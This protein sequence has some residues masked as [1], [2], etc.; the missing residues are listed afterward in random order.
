M[1]TNPKVHSIVRASAPPP[2]PSLEGL[3]RKRL[4]VCVGCGGVGKTTT[5]AALALAGAQHGRRAAVITVDP[6]RRLKDALG[7]EGLSVD[8]HRVTIDATAHFDA[9][10]L[11]TKRAFDNLVQRFAPSP[12]AAE[13]ILAN[14][15]YQEISSELAGSA[16]YMA[17]EKL[18][19]LV[20][21]HRYQLVIVDT[22]PSA[23]ARDLLAA[24]NRLVNLLA[25]RAVSILQ[26]P[27]SLLSGSSAAGR[28]TLSA[29]LKALQRWTGFD[30]LQDLADFLSG[31]ENMIEGFSLR[32]EE[33][34]RMLRSATTAFVLVTTPEPHTVD[35][36]IEFHRE[37]KT[38][39]FTVAGIIANRVLAFPRLSDPEGAA[40][41]WEEPLRGKLLRNYAELNEL[42]RRDRR[43]LKHLHAETQAPLL[44]AVPA[45]TDAPTSL[46]GLA[47][48]AR[49]LMP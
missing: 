37:L 44:A 6:A 27:A 31:F 7:L 38:A 33:V 17:M 9:L 36:T 26:A 45:V 32:A 47:R 2:L 18:H 43:A 24:P 16:E 8:P 13:R 11:D 25:S 41:A 12:E 22:P 4:I 23:H 10:A 20:H 14:R 19:E 29:L 46:A 28:L 5:A 39:G 15:L 21:H 3:L 49:L 42:S 40:I 35:T 1:S 34:N 30:L 48:F